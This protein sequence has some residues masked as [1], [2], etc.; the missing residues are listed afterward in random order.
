MD[1]DEHLRIFVDAYGCVFVNLWT[2]GGGCLRSEGGYL[3]IVV[4]NCNIY[5]YLQIFLD[6]FEN[7][8]F[9]KLDH[10]SSPSC[11]STITE[12]TVHSSI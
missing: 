10:K 7:N 9:E 2:V 4:N 5:E 1:I 8:V 11:D 3:E 6:I 12:L